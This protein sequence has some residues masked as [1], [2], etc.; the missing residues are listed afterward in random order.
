MQKDFKQKRAFEERASGICPDEPDELEQALEDVTEMEKDQQEQL[1][2]GESKKRLFLEKE[3]AET[4][5]KRAMER[6]GETRAR[7]N[8]KRQKRESMGGGETVEY[9]KKKKEQ[10]RIMREG[11]LEVKKR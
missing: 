11:E 8:V 5:R 3:T 4:M 2:I 9:L 10:E 7:E 6:M 1:S